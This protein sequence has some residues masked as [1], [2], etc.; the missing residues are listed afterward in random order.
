[1]SVPLLEENQIAP[2]GE[3]LARAFFDDPLQ[4]YFLPDDENAAACFACSLLARRALRTS[5]RSGV[6]DAVVGGRSDVAA[7]RSD[8]HDG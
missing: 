1:M 4:Q 5:L 2:A 3:A 8:R 6:H 7:A